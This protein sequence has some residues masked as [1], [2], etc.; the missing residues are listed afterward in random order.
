MN[1]PSK[2]RPEKTTLRQ[3]GLSTDL[4][5]LKAAGEHLPLASV[6]QAA[7]FD[8]NVKTFLGLSKSVIESQRVA[9][10][11]ADHGIDLYRK[12]RS[13]IT[14]LV[15]GMPTNA[16]IA[17]TWQELK[18]SKHLPSEY[19]QDSTRHANELT[20][21]A[22]QKYNQDRTFAMLTFPA[23]DGLAIVDKSVD[24]QKAAKIRATRVRQ[25]IQG[26]GSVDAEVIFERLEGTYDKQTRSIFWHFHIIVELHRIDGAASQLRSFLG[27][28]SNVL[29][30]NWAGID[31]KEIPQRDFGKVAFYCAKPCRLA[32][33]ISQANHPEEFVK[34]FSML[35]KRRMTARWGGFR[36]MNRHHKAIGKRVAG[37]HSDDGGTALTLVD[38]AKSDAP[39]AARPQVKQ[40]TA[41]DAFTS[42][43]KLDESLHDKNKNVCD[44]PL[45][46]AA[47]TDQFTTMPDKKHTNSEYLG[48]YG[49]VPGPGNRLYGYIKVRNFPPTGID[50]TAETF[51]WWHI[52]ESQK[53]LVEHWRTNT[54]E[55]YEL[56]RFLAPFAQELIK[57]LEEFNTT[58]NNIYR[59]TITVSPEVLTALKKIAGETKLN[60]TPIKRHRNLPFWEPIRRFSFEGTYC[61]CVNDTRK[62]KMY[63]TF[64]LTCL[65]KCRWRRK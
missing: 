25:L 7:K 29:G 35:R 27:E 31:L 33:E 46:T 22:N 62:E 57:L 54:E 65:E 50:A 37:F 20:F 40:Q 41:S 5:Q 32:V 3:Q 10:F 63:K 9:A 34:L 12:D 24:I 48:T 2:P 39:S 56:N 30:Q 64:F 58:Q 21:Y 49:P 42:T 17:A 61:S 16:F 26:F 60:T 45:L 28:N 59:T 1:A 15:G 4:L 53:A 23:L 14:R 6:G 44:T 13:T 38:K 36:H 43:P 19:R 52:K 18:H 8:G 47:Q 55:S 51:C 11:A